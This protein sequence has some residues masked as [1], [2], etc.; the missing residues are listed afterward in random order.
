MKALAKICCVLAVLVISQAHAG[1]LVVIVND[2][3]PITVMSRSE[4]KKHYLKDKE[5]WEFG[6][7]VRPADYKS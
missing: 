2:S 7:K 3:N 6:Q 5:R 1:E 4:V